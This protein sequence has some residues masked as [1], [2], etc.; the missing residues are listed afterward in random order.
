MKIFRTAALIF[1]FLGSFMNP[2]MN[3][4]TL[5]NAQTSGCTTS[6][7]TNKAYAAT[8]CFSIPVDGMTLI[9]DATVT[10]TLMVTGAI[11]G[12]RRFIF[13][14]DDAYLLT[15]YQKPYTLILPTAKWVDGNHS[16]SVEAVLRDSFLTQPATISVNFQNGISTPQVNTNQ[17]QPSSGITPQSGAPFVVAALGDGASGEI[18][19]E[20]VSNLIQSIAPNLVISL[21]DVYEKGTFTEFYNWY[22]TSKTLF[23]RFWSITNPTI[24]N[25]E[26]D[27]GTAEGYFDYWNNIPDYYSYD[28]GGWHFVSLNANSS[29]VKVNPQSLQYQWLQQDLAAHDEECTIVYY[30]QPLFNIG[31]EG[32]QIVMT[33]IWRLM[34]RY[35]VKIVLNGHDHDY[36]RWKP[37]DG[38]GHLDPNGI[39]EIVNGAGGHGIQTF[40]TSDSRVA[41]SND[42]N[43]L[44]FGVL[45]IQLNPAGAVFNYLTTS[46]AILDSGMIPCEKTTD[47]QFP[48]VPGNLQAVVTSPSQVDL[49]WSASSDN[50]EI[51]GYTIFRD[52]LVVTTISGTALSFS[53]RGLVPGKSYSYTVDAYDLI[54]NHSAQSEPVN[55]TTTFVPSLHM[56]LTYMDTNGDK[57]GSNSNRVDAVS[58]Q[59]NES[60]TIHRFRTRL[61]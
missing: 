54:G 28:A 12:V 42:T 47:T 14:L 8:I 17:F 57:P 56:P 35:G 21:G 55:M 34:A 29:F 60:P 36:Q 11:P 37:M 10:A 2:V 23:G 19:G 49:T 43:P 58:M 41:Y 9:G 53:D 4:A 18:N 61:C 40:I 30:H 24:G 52:G 33:D 20:L 32:T 48:S 51:S 25:H 59:M 39:T 5:L 46:G 15:D 31:P 13:Y 16:L 27:T 1:I 44:A 3:S 7:P 6:S 22:G 38:N 26:Y 45:L 50:T